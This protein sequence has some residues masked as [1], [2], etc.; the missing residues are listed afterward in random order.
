[1]AAKADPAVRAE[2]NAELKKT[3]GLIRTWQCRHC[4]WFRARTNKESWERTIIEHPVYGFISNYDAYEKDIRN[5]N[6]EEYKNAKARC[7]AR[8][9]IPNQS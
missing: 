2:R 6:C 7:I 4:S 9:G 8:W 5:H 3:F 1:M